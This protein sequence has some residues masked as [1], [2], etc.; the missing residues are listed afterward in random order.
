MTKR[1]IL[2]AALFT[3]LIASCKK[4]MNESVDTTF[5]SVIS[6]D[7]Q[8][9]AVACI[10]TSD[11][12]FILIG[13]HFV[14]KTPGDIWNWDPQFP[15][16]GIM[17]KIDQ[18]G[19]QVW[20]K[21]VDKSN[22][23]L[24]KAIP[25]KGGGFITVGFSSSGS[26]HFSIVKYDENA[27]VISVDSIQ[28]LTQWGPLYVSGSAPMDA[29]ELNN[30]DFVFMHSHNTTAT[31]IHTDADF[32]QMHAQRYDT[33]LTGNRLNIFHGLTQI[34]D[35]TLGITG[36]S[37][38]ELWTSHEITNTYL[39]TTDLNGVIKTKTVLVDSTNSETANFLGINRNGLLQVSSV[40]NGL[41]A[42]EG[43]WVD[44]YN[45]VNG[46][47]I[48]GRINLVQYD[49]SGNYKSRKK[50]YSYPGYG[51]IS[52]AK[53]TRDGGFILCG[54][55]NQSMHNTIDNRTQIYL[56]KLDENFNEQWSKVINTTY[57]SFSMDAFE[58]A[59]GGYFVAGHQFTNNERFNIV[60]IK[61]DAN[62]NY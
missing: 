60:A 2:F 8:M 56:L 45:N 62:G 23:G 28:I 36:F 29:M 18:Q 53:R 47:K 34:N 19:N 59:D 14:F 26:T 9:A 52:T 41:M 39:L 22:G 37:N 30:G 58:T 54:T 20:K 50:I 61:T 35:S 43:T 13:R 10:P 32:N 40:M 48:S 49:S 11:N 16:Q 6:A 21:Q 46:A 42:Q 7:S 57:A 3:F 38:I 12:N 31:I 5:V 17:V 1:Y 24:W 27:N 25:L 4:E 55:V 33:A 51:M 44:Y 15:S